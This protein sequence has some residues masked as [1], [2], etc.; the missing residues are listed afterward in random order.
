MSAELFKHNARPDMVGISYKGFPPAI[1]DILA[2]RH[3]T[4]IRSASPRRT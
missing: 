4:F 3:F 2:G 1:P